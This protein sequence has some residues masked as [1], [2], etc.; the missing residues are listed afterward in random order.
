MGFSP[1]A[2]PREEAGMYEPR[3]LRPRSVD[4]CIEM[5]GEKPTS[6]RLIAGG[7]DLA[8]RIGAGVERPPV[9]VDLGLVDELRTLRVDGDRVVLGSAVTHGAIAGSDA[10]ASRA[11]ALTQACRAVGSPQ[12][13]SRATIGGNIANA[14]PAADGATALLVLDAEARVR[15]PDG[16]ERAVP[17]ERFFKGPGECCLESCDLLEAVE[18]DL[19]PEGVRSVYIKAGQRNALAIAI[20]SV[21]AVLILGEG[22]RIALG[23]VAPTPV[24]ARGAESLFAETWG[25]GGD[26][27][28]ILEEVAEKAVEASSCIE[29]VRA[30]ASYRRRL[31][32]ALTLR[33]LREVCRQGEH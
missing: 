25:S 33:A 27:D 21:A 26:V 5:L 19:P 1:T 31:V 29:D 23:S 16:S 22:V 3:W 17:L 8:V 15:R 20:A 4:E 2:A 6:K 11:R 30:T 24:R 14:S 9:L 12:I 32:R 28:A 13:R 18:F 7:T 10:L